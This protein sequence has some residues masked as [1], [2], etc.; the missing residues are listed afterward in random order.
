M[1]KRERPNQGF[2]YNGRKRR[3]RKQSKEERRERVRKADKG[4]QSDKKE[5]LKQ[6]QNRNIITD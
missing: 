5:M 3:K 4:R 2:E 6:H 1:T